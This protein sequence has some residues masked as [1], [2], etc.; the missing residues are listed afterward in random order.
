MINFSLSEEQAL[1]QKTARAFARNEIAPIVEEVEK[2]DHSRWPWEVVKPVFQKAAKYGFTTLLIPEQ[3][4]GGGGTCMDNV[5]LEEELAAVDMGIA[6]SYFNNGITAPMLI[7][8][9]GNE[10]Q[11]K[12]WLGEICASDSFIIASA[13]SEPDQAGSDSLCPY[14]D[15]RIGMRTLARRDGDYYI[16]NGSKSAFTTNAGA[17]SA[18]YVIVR[19]DLNKPAFESTNFFYVPA[20]TPGLTVGKRTELIGWKTAQDAEVFL[21]NVRVHKDRMLGEEGAGLPIFLVRALPY[22]GTGFAACH[23]GLARAAY[24]YALDYA[25]QRV[26]W[27]QPIIRHQAVSLMLADMV[28]DQQAARL[29]VWDAAHAVDN[30]LESAAWKCPAAKTFAVDVA[31]RNAQTSVKVLGSYG[32]TKEYKAGKFLNDAWIGWSCDGTHVMMRLHMMNF[33]EGALPPMPPGMGPGPFPPGGPGMAG[34]PYPSREMG[35]P[36]G[37]PFPPGGPGMPG[38]PFPPGGSGMG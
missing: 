4:G 20:D 7:V 17:A 12:E 36:P 24:E 33:V 3:Y 15:P 27:L 19:T 32:V 23:V 1:L 29:M 6:C 28:V 21:D 22:I 16:I 5:L 34:G 35:M 9:G 25:K 31:I 38:G 8:L 10:R 14:P 30:H 13:G 26:S 2:L 37:G 18:Y 11:K